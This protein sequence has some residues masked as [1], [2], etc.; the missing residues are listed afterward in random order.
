MPSLAPALIVI[1]L[2]SVA[3]PAGAA[4]PP[5]LTP[6]QIAE[7][8]IP[9]IALIK[10]PSSLGTGFVVRADGRVVTN[11]HVIGGA[12]SATIVIGKREFQDVRVV[13]ADEVHDLVLLAIGAKDLVPLP[14]GDSSSIQAGESV[15]AIGHPLGLG[16][17]VSNG[18]VSAIREMESNFTMLQVSAPISPGSSG[19]PLI[20]DRGEVIGISTLVIN[21]GQNLNFGVP[22]DYL[23]E[24]L[25]VPE[26]S[27]TLAGFAV[28]SGHSR[29]RRPIPELDPGVLA[30]CP[31]DQLTRIE[32]AISRAIGVGAP[33]YNDGNPQACFRVW[34]AAALDIDRRIKRC[35]GAKKALLDGVK[36]AARREDY[37]QKAWAVRDAFDSI[38]DVIDRK[39]SPAAAAKAP[40]QATPHT[41]TVR[42]DPNLL[43]DCS[44][45]AALA[46][47]K[48]LKEAIEVGAPLYSE[49]NAEAAFRIY[50]GAALD[51]MRT[52]KRCPG[53]R[54]ALD[55]GLLR[56]TTATG[57]PAKAM[58]LRDTFAA[59]LESR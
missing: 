21:R 15:V 17:T 47:S 8:A 1:A 19:G 22:I 45:D 27:E 11:L 25:G 16:N 58:T 23:K 14:L 29:G 35:A 34:Q 55:D 51:L 3:E 52:L 12:V 54:A 26:K 38:L 39:L 56:A 40:D 18:L 6:P 37:A 4:R 30:D 41:R 53:V 2:G 24:L 43:D 46:I 32:R 9:S 44:S 50:Q 20:N 7:R 33:L 42:R 57:F 48:E 10:T 13:A 28:L 36:N 49:G 31:T 5:A 59:V